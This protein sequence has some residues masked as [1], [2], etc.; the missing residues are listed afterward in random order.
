[1]PDTGLM[2]Y[3]A[4]VLTG[5]IMEHFDSRNF[6]LKKLKLVDEKLRQHDVNSDARADY[7]LRWLLTERL[8]LMKDLQLP[9][10]G[11]DAFPQRY[12][13][14]PCIRQDLIDRAIAE[15]RIL[16]PFTRINVHSH[17]GH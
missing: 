7:E 4:D 15:N 11:I 12:Y 6:L 16:C 8:F 13:A 5:F 1:M 17:T 9:E 3:G 14:Q 2:D 10:K